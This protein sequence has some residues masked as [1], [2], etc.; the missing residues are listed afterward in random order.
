MMNE[1]S[2]IPVIV[3]ASSCCSE[4]K[5]NK[6]KNTNTVRY[7]VPIKQCMIVA[8]YLFILHLLFRG[9]VSEMSGINDKQLHISPS[10]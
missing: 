10:R 7:S 2:I 9:P 6:S 1:L 5:W 8:T 3:I 4:L